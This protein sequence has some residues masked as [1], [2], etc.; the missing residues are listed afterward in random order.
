M[1]SVP[2]RISHHNDDFRVV[3]CMGD[4]KGFVSLLVFRRLADTLREW[5]NNTKNDKSIPTVTIH[6]AAK[7]SNISY[8]KW[9]AHKDWVT[10]V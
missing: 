2:L 7:H 10:E 5:K 4:E 8:F 9:K 1:D 3:V 6:D